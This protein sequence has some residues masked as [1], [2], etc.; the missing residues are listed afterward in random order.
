MR[1]PNGIVRSLMTEGVISCRPDALLGDVARCLADGRVRAVFILDRDD[2]PLGVVS[3]FDL[4]AGEWLGADATSVDAIRQMTAAEL[5]SSPVESIDADA[6]L[7]TAAQRLEQLH[8]ARLLV[9]NDEG[10]A[11]GVLSLGDLVAA[12]AESAPARRVV[13]DVMSHAILTC[14]REAPIRAALRGM[15]ERRSRSIVVTDQGRAVGVLTARDFLRAYEDGELPLSAPVSEF[16]TSPVVSAC[17]S[18]A[19]PEAASR[20]L[21]HEIHRLVVVDD[22]SGALLGVVSTYD[23]VLQMSDSRSVW[24]TEVAFET[25]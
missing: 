10:C 23:I 25:E 24:Q 21:D 12:L 7:S 18:L 20:M 8:I 16:M 2:R 6:D 9:T 4:L 5:M 22:D 13:S 11:I 17:P 3:D 15:K 14:H 1:A 19:L